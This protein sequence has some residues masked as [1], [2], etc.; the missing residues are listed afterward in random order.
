[1]RIRDEARIL[2]PAERHALLGCL[3][4]VLL[5]E[6]VHVGPEH[7]VGHF[8]HPVREEEPAHCV[9]RRVGVQEVAAAAVAEV[10]RVHTEARH[11]GVAFGHETAAF[12][13]Q[14]CEFGWSE[15]VLDDEPSFV[16]EVA[17]VIGGDPR[18]RASH[19]HRIVDFDPGVCSAAREFL[20][21]LAVIDDLG[22]REGLDGW[23]VRHTA[24][25]LRPRTH[26]HAELE[27]NLVVRGTATYLMSDRRYDLTAGTL[28][29]LFPD[30]EHVLVNESADHALWWAVFRPSAVARIATSPAAR[31]LLERDP[32]GRYSRRVDIERVRRLGALFGE[33]S[34]RSRTSMTPR[35]TPACP[36]Y[37]HR[38]GERSWTAAT[39]SATSRSILR[40]TL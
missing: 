3:D 4:H 37:W 2:V 28:T 26:R 6:Q 1:M 11:L 39:M 13:P 27:V 16:V 25:S 14:R 34:R 15:G 23:V 38:R 35:S 7:R 18:G 29:W 24:G 5:V 12:A 22:L 30:Q 9:A 36:T 10:D 19:V 31:P 32:V 40:S 33:L 20:S 8:G 17:N 21:F